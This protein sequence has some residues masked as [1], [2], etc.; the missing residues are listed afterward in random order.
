MSTT[1]IVLIVV[2]ALMLAY[3]IFDE[4]I[5]PLRQGGTRLLVPLRRT[6]RLDTLIFVGLIGILIYQNITHNGTVLTTTLLISLVA[7]SIYLSY[8]RRPKLLFKATGFIYAN[9]FIPYTRI[10]NINLSEDGVLV[11]ELE[12]RRLLINVQQLDDLEKIYK[13]MIENQ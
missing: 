10:R 13:F 6:N 3:A 1:D 11:V 2:I 5:Q 8:I 4:F 7:I 12:K 9:I